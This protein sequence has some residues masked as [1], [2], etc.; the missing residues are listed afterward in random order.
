M[1]S[2]ENSVTGLIAQYLREQEIDTNTFESLEIPNRGV[3]EPDFVVRNQGTFY[4]EAKWENDYNRGIVEATEYHQAPTSNGTFVIA[5]PE[6]L[7]NEIGQTR[8]T[9]N[10]ESIFQKYEFPVTFL[11]RDGDTD[12]QTVSFE[13]LPEWLEGQIHARVEPRADADEVVKVLRQTADALTREVPEV[14]A[15]DLFENILGVDADEEEEAEAAKRVV[16]YLLVN[17]IVFYRVLSSA[18]DFER[19]DPDTLTSPEDLNDY[20]DRVLEQDYT[21]I[22]AINATGMYQQQHLPLIREAI[23]STYVI[24]PERIHYEVLGDIFHALIPSTLRKSVAAYYTKNRAAHLLAGVAIQDGDTTVLDPAC[25]TGTLLTAS[26]RVK[27]QFKTPFT[28]QDHRQFLE[29][30][31]TGIDIMAFAAHLAT[32]HL[33]LQN[34]Q[35]ETDRVRVGIEDSTKLQPDDEIQALSR[36]LPEDKIQRT[37]ETYDPNVEDSQDD[38]LVEQGAIA[39]KGM[40]QDPLVLDSPDLVIMNPPYS[41]QEVMSSFGG[42]Y[43]DTLKRNRLRW[44]DDYIDG[45]MNFYAYFLLL[46]DRFLED[47]GRVAAVTSVGLLNID[48][49]RGVRKLFKENY[50]LEYVFIRDDKSSFSEDTSRREIMTVAQKGGDVDATNFVRLRSLD[51]DYHTVESVA[52][53]L[54]SGE[55]DQRD[56]FTTKKV[57]TDDLNYDNLF[58]PFAVQNPELLS[59]LEEILDSEKVITLENLEP[60]IIRGAQAGAYDPRGYNPEMTIHSPDAYTFGKKDVWVLDDEND[61]TLVARHRL[62]GDTFDIPRNHVVRNMRRFTGQWKANLSDLDEYAVTKRFDDFDRFESLTM[63]DDIPVEA[64]ES[65]VESRMAH[66]TVMRRGDISAPGTAHLAYYSN[67]RR[68]WP[69]TM[70]VLTDLNASE[71]KLLTAFLD[72]TVGWLQFFVNRIETRGAYAEWHKYIIKILRVINPHSLTKDERNNLI[73]AVEAYGEVEAP[74]IVKQLAALIPNNA[75]SWREKEDF[76]EVFSDIS[77]ESGLPERR[78]LDKAV[79]SVL[80]VPDSEQEEMID[81]LYVEL[82]REISTLKRMMDSD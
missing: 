38:E 11:R 2:R 20:F 43:K 61:D 33:A 52:N 76:H 80:G 49:D 81:V 50:E 45:R 44:Y 57:A 22:F 3:K 10:V 73:N 71:A 55:T 34:P 56:N 5:Y 14:E 54:V 65:R 1:S 69:G 63:E 62:T 53:D 82:F 74:S 39:R 47:G 66:I 8:L 4:G 40:E 32:I 60:G 16:G 29:Q 72:S 31:I 67:E 41:R 27:Q 48:T 36:M 12:M 13:E 25:G 9:G 28:E 70:W 30:D 77:F 24:N 42:E 35:Y 68:L 37:L 19:I 58:A 59:I 17:Q 51:V 18:T 79:L 6:A 26:Y 15:I 7:K 64:W 78:S 21:P 23:A 75:L 46:A